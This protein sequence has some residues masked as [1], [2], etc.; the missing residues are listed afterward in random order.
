MPE[1]ETVT[2][3][4]IE[5]F[6]VG[7]WNGHGYTDADLD[8]MVAAFNELRG[9]VDAPAKLGQVKLGHDKDQTL[10]TRSGY[11]A[12]GWIT[13]LY[14]EGPHV[15]ADIGNVPKTLGSLLKSGAY[16]HCSSELLID[17][18]FNGKKYPFVFSGLAFL[19]EEL[20]GVTDLGDVVDLYSLAH[21]KKGGKSK[22]ITYAHDKAAPTAP[23]EGNM[24]KKDEEAA[25]VVQLERLKTG[26]GLASFARETLSRLRSWGRRDH[27]DATSHEALRDALQEAVDNRFGGL[28]G[29][30]WICATYDDRVIVQKADTYYA[31][32]YL[33]ADDGTITFNEAYEVEQTWTAASTPASGGDLPANQPATPATSGDTATA[34]AALTRKEQQQ[35]K[36]IAHALGL[37]DDATEAE[38]V[39]AIAA[40]PTAE[41]FAT[42]QTKV[43]DL[44]AHNLNA[45]AE[46][47][48][49]EAIRAKKVAPAS[50]AEMLPFARQDPKAFAA[51]V[52]KAPAIFTGTLGSDADAPAAKSAGDEI[53]NK[54]AELMKS[55]GGKTL[56]F[57]AALERVSREN[58]D[59]ARKYVEER[60][61]SARLS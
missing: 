29:Y 14:R 10:A 49:D 58:P 19:G 37:K 36:T 16:R 55:D 34:T 56:S 6:S 33:R 54:V 43:T 61:T 52:E 59:L 7:T 40:R 1:L 24:A 22:V 26:S 8:S 31:I 25:L 51:F 46:K 21:F 2:L 45:S 42:I 23:Q 35:M 30:A 47:S 9:T 48:V 13:K 12:V 32:P 5:V 20:P 44:E 53:N 3:S 28:D 38:I 11:P 57:A 18:T 39:A 27:A 15:L 41:Q 50:R 4:A 17:A 60:G